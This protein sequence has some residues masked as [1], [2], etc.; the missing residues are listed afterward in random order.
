MGLVEQIAF[1]ARKDVHVQVPDILVAGRFVVL[2][3]GDAP[4]AVGVSNRYRNPLYRFMN[5]KSVRRRQ[6]VDVFVM[7][8]RNDENMAF[9]IG[10]PSW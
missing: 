2:A 9:V 8:V 1:I 10:P 7:G 3:R 5:R 6:V 4:A